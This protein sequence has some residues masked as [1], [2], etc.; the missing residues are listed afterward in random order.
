MMSCRKTLNF[1]ITN[2]SFQGLDELL[3][4]HNI[5]PL[6]LNPHRTL[7]TS[8]S[9]LGN[10]IV[11]TTDDL[12]FIKVFRE[13]LAAILQSILRNFPE[14]IF[15]DFD[16]LVISMLRQAL[17][18]E[19][20]ADYF[21]KFFAEKIELLM[22]LFGN[23]S[24]IRFRYLHDFIYG[25]DWAKWVQKEPKARN[26]IEPFNPAFLDY[27]LS[28]GQEILQLICLGDRQYHHLCEN[29]YRNPF[30]FSREPKDEIRLFT[31]LAR[32]KLIPVAAWDWNV[33]PVWNKPFHQMR[34]SISLELHL[35]KTN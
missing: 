3:K 11:Q 28:R 2:H 20:G 10:L 26:L 14:N 32:Q 25:F 1:R 12:Q 34:E 19:K 18:A 31:Y 29:L 22:D 15:W 27:L 33:S 16:Y 24:E 17:V 7:S 35:V 5:K 6:S 9:A 23:K 21:L 30:D 8:F 13:T 4:Q